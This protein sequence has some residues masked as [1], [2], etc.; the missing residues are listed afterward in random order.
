V[1]GWHRHRHHAGPT[2]AGTTRRERGVGTSTGHQWGLFHGHGQRAA[3]GSRTPRAASRRCGAGT[4]QLELKV[5]ASNSSRPPGSGVPPQ[6]RLGRVKLRGQVQRPP[7]ARA[8]TGYWWIRRF[9]RKPERGLVSTR[10][11]ARPQ[12]PAQPS[13]QPC[14]M[15]SADSHQ[16]DNAAVR[17]AKVPASAVSSAPVALPGSRGGSRLGS[18]PP[19]RPSRDRSQTVLN[20]R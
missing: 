4:G 17:W 12:G 20:R 7:T 1:S 6:A 10:W 11:V 8:S 5:A 9:A 3:L 2:R 16:R 19:A 15:P 18:G 13:H 14:P